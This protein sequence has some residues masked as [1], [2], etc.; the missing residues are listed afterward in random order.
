MTKCEYLV[1]FF[2]HLKHIFKFLQVSS[3]NVDSMDGNMTVIKPTFKIQLL[4]LLYPQEKCRT[5]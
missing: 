5:K 2:L 3:S 1:Y 4:F